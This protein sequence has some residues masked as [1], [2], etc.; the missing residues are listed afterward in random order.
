VTAY[1][2]EQNL[3]LKPS[4]SYKVFGRHILGSLQLLNILNS[5]AKL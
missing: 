4:F 3:A 5:C 1:V 2:T